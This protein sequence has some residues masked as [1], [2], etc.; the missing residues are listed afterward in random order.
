MN[1]RLKVYHEGITNN[2]NC[3]GLDKPTKLV[4]EQKLSLVSG[5]TCTTRSN[6]RRFCSTD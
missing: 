6:S 2:L 4:L 3:Q 1:L 5:S